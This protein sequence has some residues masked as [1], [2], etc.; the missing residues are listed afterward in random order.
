MILTKDKV[1]NDLTNLIDNK[2][3]EFSKKLSPDTNYKVLGI[4]VPDLRK[5]GKTYKE[6][7]ISNY[8]LDKCFEIPNSGVNYMGCF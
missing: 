8:L 2:Y 6:Y 1:L 3:Q 4:R 7:N 5:L